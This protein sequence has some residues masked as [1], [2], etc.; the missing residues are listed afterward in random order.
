MLQ[1][2]IKAIEVTTSFIEL[3]KAEVAATT[4]LNC[5]GMVNHV[6]KNSKYEYE[7]QIRDAR[8]RKLEV[9]AR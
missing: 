4:F 1:T 3:E 5:L 7:R 6:N 9:L 8:D 2:H